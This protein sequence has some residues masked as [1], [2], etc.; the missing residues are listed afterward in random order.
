M[1][2]LL[3]AM[4]AVFGLSMVQSGHVAAQDLYNCPDFANQEIAQR[5][6]NSDPSDPSGLDA[7]NDGWACESY[8]GYLGDVA[9]ADPKS[10]PDCVVIP[11]EVAAADPGGCGEA[12]NGDVSALPDTG[13]GPSRTDSTP[14]MSLAIATVACVALGLMTRRA[15][16]A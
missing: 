5:Y 3:V 4:L 14:V 10:P 16:R 7:D 2:R 13:H 6:L 8:F 9:P 1:S 15:G 12:T 11:P